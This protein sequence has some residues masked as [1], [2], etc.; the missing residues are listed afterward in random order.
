M[1]SLTRS[2]PLL[3]AALSLPA[4]AGPGDA[5]TPVPAMPPAAA[6]N[7]LSFADGKVVLDF[8][9]RMRFEYRENNFDF[10][11]SVDSLTD[12]SWFLQ[13]VRLGVKL[14]PVPW[15][16]LYV[17]AQD[18]REL[19]ADRPNVIGTMGAEG[20]DS[21]DLRQA[22][23][24]VGKAKGLSLTA[25]RQTLTYGDERLVGPLDWVNQGRTFDAVKLRYEGTDWA[26][27]A[28]TSSVVKF[29]QGELN[30]SD[31]FDGDSTRNQFFS[32]LYFTT[33]KLGP[34]TTDL[35]VFHLHEEGVADTNFFTFGT[36]VKA[37]VKKTGGLDYEL[38]LA[39]QTG[40]VKGKDL[41]AFAAHA[42]AGYVWTANAMKP[43]VFAEYNYASG[44]E[45]AADG[46]VGT[47]QNLFPT[48]HKFYGYM[49]FFSWQNL[50]NPAISASFS[51]AKDV[52]VRVDG[53]FF[54]LA[55][56]SDAWYRANGVTQVRPANAKA[57]SYVGSEVDLTV[58]WKPE[59]WLSLQAGYSHFFA[60]S[61]LKA[62]GA[63]DDADFF[64]TSLQIDF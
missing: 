27:D 38:E 28:F 25:G 63:A 44:D 51:P 7:P 21:F 55:D 29:T 30:K 12:D 26:L 31:W 57:S 37:D 34:Q 16:S 42:G 13:R 20:D 10:N 50:H 18:T 39:A 43:R 14:A 8:Q 17:Q 15:L 47:F 5:K 32:G 49:D 53:Q 40:E 6:P 64:Y 41:A 1:Y 62:S 46:D 3:L 48:N 59:K 19:G 61:H 2:V 52:T 9:E 23:V 35:Y 4:L 54:W 22:Y 24:R 33:T 58:A 11:D 45:N 56:T 36:R 60:G